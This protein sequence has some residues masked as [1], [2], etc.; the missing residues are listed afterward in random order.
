MQTSGHASEA[1]TARESF[2]SGGGVI[3]RTASEQVHFKKATH[4]ATLEGLPGQATSSGHQRKTEKEAPCISTSLS[5][6]EFSSATIG[7]ILP[8]TP[9]QPHS[10][11]WRGMPVEPAVTKLPTVPML[12]NPEPS[13]APSTGHF[14]QAGQAMDCTGASGP[15]VP[16]PQ[17]CWLPGAGQIG[18]PG[19]ALGSM[20]PSAAS[21]PALQ[22]QHYECSLLQNLH[23]NE[24]DQLLS[25]L[26]CRLWAT[27]Q[28]LGL[29]SSFVVM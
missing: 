4:S 17:P 9:P 24:H 23:A 28:K 20:G 14:G 2:D 10:Q 15:I 26:R 3:T 8:K 29:M 11:D 27:F 6:P 22:V 5:V 13:W 12:P 1:T 18:H 19:Q 21:D 7:P 16:S 25:H